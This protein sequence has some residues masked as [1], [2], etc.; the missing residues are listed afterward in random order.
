[1]AGDIKLQYVASVAPTVTNLHSL[2]SSQDWLA[3]WTGG[4]V[5]NLTNEYLDYLYAGTFTTH[6]SNRQAGS[7]NVYVIAALNDTPTWPATASGTIGTEG[8]LSFTDTEER[9]SLVRL[10]AS[11]TVDN[12]ASAIYTF[13]PTGIAQM[14]GGMVP[15]YHAI[16]VAQNCATTTAAGL[17]AAGSAIYYT[18]VNAQYT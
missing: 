10:L 15:P 17:A 3:G 1:M 5:S 14:F 12:T 9:D 18:P 16:Y 13:P 8:A 7:I 4:S 11:I 2:A 6:A